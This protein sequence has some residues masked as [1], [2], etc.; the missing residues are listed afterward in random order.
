MSYLLQQKLDEIREIVDQ[1]SYGMIT[2]YDLER[3]KDKCMG[4]DLHKVQFH[5]TI[6]WIGRENAFYVDTHYYGYWRM[7]TNANEWTRIDIDEEEDV[8]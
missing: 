1:S 3:L 7:E 8:A 2:S 5:Y 6:E 4:D